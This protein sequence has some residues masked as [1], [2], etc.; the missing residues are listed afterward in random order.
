MGKYKPKEAKRRKPKV[1]LLDTKETVRPEVAPHLQDIID[2]V[3]R[4]GGDVD[5][6]TVLGIL[7]QGKKNFVEIRKEL[8]RRSK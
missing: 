1:K 2:A 3:E 6:D 8:E 5:D 7:R 4:M